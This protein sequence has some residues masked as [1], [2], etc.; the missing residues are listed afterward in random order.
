MVAGDLWRRRRTGL[1][2]MATLIS[3]ADGN[4]TG[5]NTFV[6]TD[7]GAGSLPL[8]KI[9]VAPLLSCIDDHNGCVH[10]RHG[11]VIDGVLLF[12][13]QAASDHWHLQSGPSGRGVSQSSCTV[14]KTDLPTI[15]EQYFLNPMLFA[16][17]TS[18][19]MWCKLTLVLTTTGPSR[20]RILM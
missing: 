12:V 7:T 18:R 8:S 9:I 3:G 15:F 5:T 11:S 17:P 19:V 13:K 1:H 16:G 20:F 4:L 10:G 14:S 2:L 6:A